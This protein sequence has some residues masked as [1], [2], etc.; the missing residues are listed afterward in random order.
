MDGAPVP[1]FHGDRPFWRTI[2]DGVSDGPDV[3]QLEQNLQ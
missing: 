2:G 3:T 1:L